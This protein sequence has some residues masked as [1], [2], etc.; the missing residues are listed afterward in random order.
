[1][2][3]ERI[4]E[5]VENVLNEFPEECKKNYEE[6]KKDVIIKREDIITKNLFGSYSH[7]KNIIT[8]Y[9]DESLAHELFHMAFRDRNKLN[10]ELFYDTNLIYDNGVSYY[11]RLLEHI[12][13]MALTEG[14]AEYLSRK[15][16]SLKGKN[17]EYY[18]VNLLIK[19]YGEE[20]IKYPLT[21]DSLNFY[22]DDRFNNI[23]D[24]RIALD[25]LL[26]NER[27]IIL[28]N[29]FYEEL[30][31]NLKNNKHVK[32]T[33]N[34]MKNITKCYVESIKKLFELMILEYTNC[35]NPKISLDDFI[36]LL[37]DFL[38]NN[39]YQVVFEVAKIDNYPLRENIE[40]IIKKFK[41]EYVKEKMK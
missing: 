27:G 17:N 6:N 4:Y 19:I 25:S 33:Y 31:D 15:C 28:C 35:L 34:A 11:N 37:N 3:I 20:I 36:E 13:G 41:S 26:E 40:E 39:D 29:H 38:I 18:F 8:L 23:H 10:V 22:Q 21:N 14:F 7:K 30:I 5:L 9:N 24:I 32:E 16:C 1:M 12:N 2:N